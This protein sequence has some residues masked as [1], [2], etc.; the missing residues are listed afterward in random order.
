MCEKEN[1]DNYALDLTLQLI[2]QLNKPV[3]T[4]KK[5]EYL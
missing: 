5:Y 1:C 2:V 3:F 4:W